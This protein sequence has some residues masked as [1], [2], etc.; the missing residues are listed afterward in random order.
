[1]ERLKMFPFEQKKKWVET[2]SLSYTPEFPGMVSAGQE[3][4]T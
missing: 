3:K 4:I 2:T 1:V